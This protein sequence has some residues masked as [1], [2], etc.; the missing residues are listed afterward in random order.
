MSFDPDLPHNDLPALPPPSEV[1]TKAVMRQAVKSARALAELKGLGGI[2]PDQ[3]MLV[4]SLV[5]QEAK[6][7]SEVENVIT[8]NDALFKA[9]ASSSGAD[10]Q[11]KEVLR[12]RHAIWKGFNRLR[13]G[14]SF[15][16]ALF[17]DLVGRITGDTQGVRKTSGTQLRK[18]QSGDVIYTPPEGK[19][20]LLQMLSDL[21][22]FADSDPDID[23]LIKMALFHY[24]FEAIHPFYDGNGRTGRLLNI[25]YLVKEGLLELPVLYL[26]KYIID[27]KQDYYRKLRWVTLNNDWES[28]ILF[29]LIAVEETAVSTRE[30]VLGIRRL[31]DGALEKA[32]SELPGHMYSK[33][34]VEL[35]FSH[36]YTKVKFLVDANIAARQTA[37]EYLK[38]LERIGLLRSH[39]VGREILYLN[40]SLYEYLAS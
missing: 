36:P 22:D 18:A 10:A 1:E 19:E 15:S 20:Q 14:E 9:M 5:L 33:E 12:Y 40:V 13:E 7:S 6:A 37:A 2:I 26:S 8:T 30:L 29:M 21:I 35:L 11:T 25:L 24:Q 34:L 27:H 32:K 38:E 28:W 16:I 39:K 4:D 23:P 17:E 3:S 31:L